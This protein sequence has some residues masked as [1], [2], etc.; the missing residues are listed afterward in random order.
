MAELAANVLSGDFPDRVA[1]QLEVADTGA[2]M[3][4]ATRARIFDPFFTTKFTGRGLGLAV[5][6]GIVQSHKGA[7]LV[8]S[9]PGRGTSFSVFF[10]ALS[11]DTV[12][13]P[14][15]PAARRARWH[16]SGTV[17]VVDDEVGVRTV[18]TR[19]LERSGYKV[20]T[21]MDGRA[22]LE[23]FR[24]QADTIDCVLLDLTMPQLSGQQTF[25]EMR[26]LK[27]DARIVVMSGYAEEEAS[28]GFM[29]QAVSGFLHKPFTI[30]ELREVLQAVLAALC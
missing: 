20:L 19:I 28:V 5:V 9:E 2:G 21:A 6:Q 22:G 12:E 29:G 13:E 23:I 25:L 26:Q 8:A 16:G 30:E 7:L 4:P 27:P 14:P 1:V 24:A 15:A 10:P 3:D 18:A 17:L 11:A